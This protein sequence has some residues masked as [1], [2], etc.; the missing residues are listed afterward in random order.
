MLAQA[1]QDAIESHLQQLQEVADR[2]RETAEQLR[3]GEMH[4]CHAANRLNKLAG[5]LAKEKK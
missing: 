5:Q 1:Q 3:R 2:L 4:P